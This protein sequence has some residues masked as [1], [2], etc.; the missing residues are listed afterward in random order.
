MLGFTGRRVLSTYVGSS[1]RRAGLKSSCAH[2]LTIV[3]CFVT[4]VM[5][6]LNIGCVCH[7]SHLG[8]RYGGSVLPFRIEVPQPAIDDLRAR[9]SSTRWPDDVTGAAPDWSWGTP[10]GVL[11]EVAAYWRDEYDWRASEERWNGFAQYLVPT[12][13]GRIH[14][15]RAGTPGRTPLMLIHGWPDGFPRFEK[16]IP[17]LADRFDL[18]IPSIPGFGF[19]DRPRHPGAGPSRIADRFAAVMSA[20]GIDHFAVH[21]A[22]LGSTVAEALGARHPDRVTALHLGDVPAWH[23]YTVDPATTSPAERAFLDGMASWFADEGAYAGLQRTKPQTLAFA[24]NDSPVGLASW[25]VEKL[26]AW[27]DCSGDVFSRFSPGEIA[28]WVSLYWFTQ[29]AG[30]AARHYREGALERRDDARRPSAPTGLTLFG[31]DIACP[32]REYA[33]RFFDVRHFAVV[34][35]GGHFGP[36]EEPELW[37]ADL[38]AFLDS[39]L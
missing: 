5:K 18:V 29:T 9:L 25:I 2:T 20:L 26:R 1:P 4:P 14:V 8:H 32:P 13:G 11:R 21:G 39:A 16:A 10:P 23:R 15:V 3:K 17:L 24:L 35:Q 30:S 7:G 38:T 37:A 36:W 27:S 12:D 34:A 28:D 22:D 33:E 31:H 6:S 19:S